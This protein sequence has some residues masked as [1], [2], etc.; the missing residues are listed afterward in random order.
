LQH[1][2]QK[3]LSQTLYIVKGH[4]AVQ[5]YGQVRRIYKLFITAIQLKGA[6]PVCVIHVRS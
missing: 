5:M 6:L 4:S 2:P 1:K 3:N